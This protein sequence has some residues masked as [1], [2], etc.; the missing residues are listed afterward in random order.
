MNISTDPFIGIRRR[1]SYHQDGSEHGCGLLGALSRKADAVGRLL[2][3]PMSLC[4]DCYVRVCV[5]PIKPGYYKKKSVAYREIAYRVTLF[6]MNTI[7]MVIVVL[8]TLV[9][10]LLRVSSYPKKKDFIWY[11]AKKP[12]AAENSQHL[13]KKT[14]SIMTYNMAAMPQFIS[15]RNLLRPT[16]ERAQEIPQAIASAHADLPDF[17]CGQEVFD[18]EASELIANGLIDKGY[19]SIVRN[20][21]VQMFGLSSGLFLA[22]K[23]RLSNVC[24]YPHAYHRGVIEHQANKGVLIATAHIGK[25]Q[26]VIATTHLSGGAPGGGFLPRSVQI[27]GVMAHIDRYVQEILNKNQT[28]EGVFLSADTNI[29]PTET[30]HERVVQEPE[31]YLNPMLCKGSSLSF[32]PQTLQKNAAQEAA[33]CLL[34]E[35]HTTLPKTDEI[36]KPNAW[37]K[38]LRSVQA[39]HH[40]GLYPKVTDLSTYLREELPKKLGGPFPPDLYDHDLDSLE[41]AMDGSVLDMELSSLTHPDHPVTKPV[42]LDFNFTRTKKGFINADYLRQP[43]NL[44]STVVH[45]HSTP[46]DHHPVQ[47]I[48]ALET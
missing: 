30:V 44:G 40:G 8:P 11:G 4:I 12:E 3:R 22:S 28:L 9:G 43:K 13:N 37:H 27:K 20:V 41:K 32:N 42:R 26:I 24:F 34:K 19:S 31:W 36:M 1:S 18:A 23:Y 21:G 2:T 47:T 14:I 35:L 6:F 39:I 17:I 46:S 7:A 29:S 16:M 15:R 45:L 48:F 10:I 38:Y 25:K 33:E 5:L